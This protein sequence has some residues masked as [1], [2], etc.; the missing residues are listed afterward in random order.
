[1]A[2][3]LSQQTLRALTDN[4]Q[5]LHRLLDDLLVL[6][7][8]LGRAVNI[9]AEAL[10]GGHKVL[11]CGNGG[12]AADAGHF[13]TALVGRYVIE[14]PG[15]PAI[16]LTTGGTILTALVND[17]PPQEMFARQV[18]AYGQPG[19]VLV[20][21]SSTGNSPNTIVAVQTARQMQM[22]TIAFLGRGGGRVRGM[23]DVEL[24]VPAKVTARIHESHRILYHTMLD[25]LDSVLAQKQ[26]AGSGVGG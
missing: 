10:T 18:R 22:K 19:D 11:V 6:A 23:V 13:V 14:K 12:S 9:L 21:F 8:P 2:V 25:V 26:A 5:A 1:M 17:Y 3:D 7:E 24:I 4:V 15:R 20:V 16:D